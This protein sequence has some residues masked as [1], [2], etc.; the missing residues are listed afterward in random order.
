MS[1]TMVVGMVV[2]IAIYGITFGSFS[3]YLA[4]EKG[5]MGIDWFVLGAL[6]GPIALLTVVGLPAR[7]KRGG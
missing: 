4:S 3:A 5:R 7:I 2:L 1:E 6:F